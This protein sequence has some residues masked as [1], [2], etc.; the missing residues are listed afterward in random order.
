M[1]QQSSGAKAKVTIGIDLGDRRSRVY[2][3]D[4]EGTCIQEG[5]V[6]AGRPAWEGFLARFSEARVVMEAGTHSPWVSRLASSMGHE[7]I[8]GNPSEIYGHRRR[9]RRNDTLDAEQLA[10]MGR[11]DPALLS[12]I[13]HRGEQA[14]L[15]LAALQSRDILVKS[16]TK[17][18]NHVRGSVKA[19]GGR[20]PAC[21]AEAFV[22]HVNPDVPESLQP[23]LGPVLR[24]ITALTDE[25]RAL[26]RTVERRTKEAYPETQRL[27]QIKGVGPLTSLCYVLVLEDP[28]RFKNPREA[29]SYL[30]LV[31]RLDETG[32]SQP[33][34]PITKAGNQLLRTYLVQSA[35][36]ILGPFG[37]DTDLRRWGL[38]LMTRGG[39]NAKKR[40]VIAVARKL[41]VL[42]HRLWETGAPYVPLRNEQSSLSH[43]G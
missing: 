27:R 28:K 2:V 40:A 14:Q 25:I 10:R 1:T 5:W 4:A 7:V 13:Q 18:I 42:L 37:N 30:G 32:E 41:A 23:A 39:K 17:L 24:Q 3:L 9:K 8:V 19:V 15:D 26:D 33:Q 38:S 35:Q 34:L 21:S 6:H 11:V 12:P 16:R 36:Y 20:L 22:T 29:G 43:A 31:P